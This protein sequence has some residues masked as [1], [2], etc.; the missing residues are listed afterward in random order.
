MTFA[1]LR[2]KNHNLDFAKFGIV[3]MFFLHALIPTT[4]YGRFGALVNE[5]VPSGTDQML[6]EEDIT[7]LL[8]SLGIGTIACILIGAV[9]LIRKMNNK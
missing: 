1:S 4:L 8:L 3:T 9:F 2:Q 6:K 5:F 7:L